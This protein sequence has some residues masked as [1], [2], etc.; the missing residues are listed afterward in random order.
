MDLTPKPLPVDPEQVAGLGS[1]LISSH[2]ENNYLGALSRLNTIRQTLESRDRAST[3]GFALVGAKRE[4]LLAANS[5]FLHEAYFDA[6]GG[7][8]SLPAGGLSVAVERDFGSFENWLAEFTSLARAMGGGSG[9]AILAWSAREARLL[10]HWAGDHSQ[11]LAGTSTLLALDMYEHAYHMDFGAKA[12]AYIDAFMA[13]IRWDAV[14]S[15][16]VRAMGAASAELG[17]QAREAANESRAVILDVRRRPAFDLAREQI[18]GSA[19]RDPAM[20][21]T[22]Q[23]ELENARTVMVYCVKGHEVSQSVALA[24]R[25]RGIAARFLIGGIDAWREAGL[26]LARKAEG[27]SH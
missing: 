8:G 27:T 11:L 2:Y 20:A 13:Q 26:P 1:K 15:T 16:Y 4:E 22:W 9:W 21:L 3:P 24:L 5:V 6:L 10:N 25:A 7:D 23:H 12:S 17:I 19:W 18:P 14:A